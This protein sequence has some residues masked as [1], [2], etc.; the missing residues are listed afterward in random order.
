MRARLSLAFGAVALLVVGAFVLFR[1]VTITD[2][3]EDD[4]RRQ[5]QRE[6]LVLA[7]LLGTGLEGADRAPAPAALAPFAH[8]DREVTVTLADGR[9]STTTGDAWVEAEADAALAGS[10]TVDGVTV[11]VRA[12]SDEVDRAVSAALP[13]L[14]ALAA[15]L[16]ALAVV[17][18]ALVATLVTRPFA[19]LAGAAHALARGRS[20]LLLPRTRIPEARAIA[21]ALESGAAQLGESL[22]RERDLSLRASHELR[23][24]LTSLRLALHDLT[25]RDDAPPD[26]LEAAAQAARQVDRLDQAVGEVLDDTRRHPVVATAQ[27]PLSLVVPALAQRWA[28][29]LDLADVPLEAELR[30][31]AGGSITPGPV[32][33]VLDDVLAAVL[34]CRG[35][36]VRLVVEESERHVR[37]TV[38]VESP[39]VA[40]PD[41]ADAPLARARDLVDTIG[42]RMSGDLAG[43]EGLVVVVP[44]R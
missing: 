19:Q 35:R 13:S 23:T 31:D 8:P 20:D 28:D 7:T 10:A 18:G 24:P 4:V 27:L 38:V 15:A 1:V 2:L 6:S 32:E 16:V 40:A 25:D 14:V 3:A 21:A 39:A 17:L 36:R 29:T 42:G 34:A 11:Q 12:P 33:Q 26:L 37:T 44:R 5:V 43:P 22:R 30:G 41:G 9:R